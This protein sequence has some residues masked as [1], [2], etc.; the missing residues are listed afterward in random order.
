MATM[1]RDTG[2]RVGTC[3]MPAS[4]IAAV[5]RD[6]RAAVARKA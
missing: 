5:V 6:L 2:A 1:A 4:F 3:I